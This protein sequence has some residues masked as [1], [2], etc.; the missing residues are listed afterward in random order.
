M[1][2]DF[3]GFIFSVCVCVF[4]TGKGSVT[5]TRASVYIGDY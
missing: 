4:I 5:A 1:G 3:L 2:S